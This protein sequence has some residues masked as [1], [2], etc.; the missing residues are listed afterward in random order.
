MNAHSDHLADQPRPTMSWFIVALGIITAIGPLSIDMYLPAF[1]DIAAHLEADM[2]SVQRSLTT[3]FIGLTLGQ[4]CYGP[5]A[6]RFGRKRPL[7]VGLGIYLFACIG[8]ALATNIET[9]IV[10]RGLQALGAAAG[11]VITRAMVRD[12]FH[13][14]HSA[15]VFS[16]LMLVMGVAPILGPILG[17]WVSVALG[18]R[19]VFGTLGLVSVACLCMT[20]RMAETRPPEKRTTELNVASI[21]RVYLGLFKDRQFVT[22]ALTS[23]LAMAGMFG[24]IAGAPFVLMNLYGIP[25]AHFGWVFGANALGL[26]IATQVNSRLLA[27]FTFQK[28]LTLATRT[29]ALAALYLMVVSV[30]HA[31]FWLIAPGMFVYVSMLGFILPNATAGAMERQAQHAGAAAALQGT[32]LFAIA[33]LA[34]LGVSVL[35]D[36]T[37]MPMALLMVLTAGGAWANYYF[38]PI[39]K[40]TLV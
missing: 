13:H 23:G 6:D 9:L 15:R 22:Y 36:G 25:Q 34:T 18:W 21:V 10:M 8:C 33:S 4:L 39:R 5:I 7:Q 1:N 26:V 12:R 3:Y 29:M 14:N 38:S 16:L 2:S 32:M 28:I 20:M 17:G 27:R 37:A 31:P 30:A 40:P 19:A 11:A 35:H 24:Y